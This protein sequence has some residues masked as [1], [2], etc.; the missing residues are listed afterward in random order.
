MQE[1]NENLI[2]TFK[3]IYKENSYRGYQIHDLTDFKSESIDGEM[4][5]IKEDIITNIKKYLNIET[6]KSSF[7]YNDI[8]TI[9][10]GDFP[11]YYI[12]EKVDV[13]FHDHYMYNSYSKDPTLS[14]QMYDDSYFQKTEKMAD[15]LRQLD[16]DL[17]QEQLDTFDNVLHEEM[18]ELMVD[19]EGYI[20]D[21]VMCYLS[22]YY[23]TVDVQI[24]LTKAML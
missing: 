17:D 2:L 12:I 19:I 1:S 24:T 11:L 16:S 14:T 6:N 20:A 21:E 15:E 3:N 7:I 5:D 23:Y 4:E 9:L 10:E 8:E 13:V 18:Q 22:N